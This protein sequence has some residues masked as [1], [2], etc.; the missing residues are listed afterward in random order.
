MSLTAVIALNAVLDLAVIL[1]LA[2]V[3]LRPFRFDRAA[4]Y[5]ALAAT[6]IPERPDGLRH[7]A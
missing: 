3:M 2:W 5:A 1:A 7:A 4:R 6:D